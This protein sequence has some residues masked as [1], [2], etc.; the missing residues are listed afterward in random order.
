MNRIFNVIFNRITNRLEVVSELV[1][2]NKKSSSGAKNQTTLNSA[3]GKVLRF[4][5]LSLIAMLLSAPTL[6]FAAD[7]ANT[8][9]AA[10]NKPQLK[11][12]YDLNTKTLK[13]VKA[14][15]SELT[16]EDLAKLKGQ[17][18]K[19]DSD[20][21]TINFGNPETGRP[22]SLIYDNAIEIING[23]STSGSTATGTTTTTSGSPTAVS[24]ASANNM[25]NSLGSIDRTIP[26]A[27]DSSKTVQA[28]GTTPASNPTQNQGT[29]NIAYDTQY[30]TIQIL[31][32]DGQ[33]NKPDMAPDTTAG[34]SYNDLAAIL[35]NPK[36]GDDPAT[37][38]TVN[39]RLAKNSIFIGANSGVAKV[40]PKSI[41]PMDMK[42]YSVPIIKS[43]GYFMKSMKKYEAYQEGTA[44][45]YGL[46]IRDNLAIG[47]NAR[48]AEDWI[49][50]DKE[51]YLLDAF[52]ERPKNYADAFFYSS[53]SGSRY[54]NTVIGFSAVSYATR[55]T[56]LGSQSIV[57]GEGSVAI[58]DRAVAVGDR[59]ISLGS[60]S[61]SNGGVRNYALGNDDVIIGSASMGFGNTS[62]SIGRR[63]VVGHPDSDKISKDGNILSVTQ[64]HNN[65]GKGTQ[66]SVAVGVENV[67]QGKNAYTVGSSNYARGNNTA[68]MGYGV[69]ITDDR[70]IGIGTG[71]AAGST[72][73]IGDY[74]KL[75]K[76]I[77]T[78]Q[79][80]SY[81]GV[82]GE[83]YYRKFV[84]GWGAA[85]DP[86]AFLVKGTAAVGLGSYTQVN[87]NSAVALATGE[88]PAFTPATEAEKTAWGKLFAGYKENNVS[89][90]SLF[91]IYT[92]AQTKYLNAVATK[93][94]EANTLADLKAAAD[95]AKADLT[96][97][98]EEYKKNYKNSENTYWLEAMDIREARVALQE[99][100]D[101][102]T[103][104]KNDA[105]IKTKQA[106]LDKL[107]AAFRSKW[108]ASTYSFVEG[109]SAVGI[110]K[111]INVSGT[112]ALGVGRKVQVT[113]DR[114]LAVGDQAMALSDDAISFGGQAIA[115]GA[116]SMALGGK[117]YA[118]GE[119]ALAIGA[120]TKAD[121]TPES[122]VNGA[123]VPLATAASGSTAEKPNAL[124]MGAYTSV[125]G[126]NSLAIGFGKLNAQGLAKSA[127]DE[128]LGSSDIDYNS[129]TGENSIL[130]GSYSLLGADNS[131]VLGN[132][133]KIVS[134]DL[135]DRAP[136]PVNSAILGTGSIVTGSNSILIGN[137]GNIENDRIMAFGNYIHIPATDP[138]DMENDTSGSVFLGDHAGYVK[139]SKLT[140][141]LGEIEVRGQNKSLNLSEWLSS[142]KGA[143]KNYTD[144][145]T[146]V[147]LYEN[148]TTNTGGSATNS[149]NALNLAAAAAENPKEMKVIAVKSY[150]A[151]G[152]STVGVVSVGS[153]YEQTFSGDTSEDRKNAIA[154]YSAKNG[155]NIT[156]PVVLTRPITK[157]GVNI[158]Q[159]KDE[160][161]YFSV[162][163]ED[164]AK[165][166]AY[167]NLSPEE[168][169]SIKE[170]IASALNDKSTKYDIFE[171][172]RIQNVAPGLIGMNSTD[173]INGSQLYATNQMLGNLVGSMVTL[174]GDAVDVNDEGEITVNGKHKTLGWV[175]KAD[176]N[177]NSV[178]NDITYIDNKNEENENTTNLK[179][180]GDTISPSNEYTF[181]AGDNIELTQKVKSLTIA[182]AK[183]LMDIG[184]ITT[185]ETADGKHSVFNPNGFATIK[186]LQDN[187][188]NPTGA[189]QTTTVT[190][191]G[192]TVTT[193][194]PTKENPN[195]VI[196]ETSLT[197]DGLSTDGTVKVMTGLDGKD[198][199]GNP[200]ENKAVVELGKEL[201]DPND[202]TKSDNYYGTIDLVGK[203]NS[204]GT[205]F[206][207]HGDTT[208]DPSKNVPR[209]K[210][211][212]V[213]PNTNPDGAERLTYTTL[214][215]NDKDGKPTTIT[216]AI[217]TMDDGIRL[218]TSG[219]TGGTS[220]VSVLMN[221]TIR[222]ID[223]A[224]TVVSSITSSDGVHAFHID[225]NGL[226]TS[227]VD[228][229]GKALTKLGDKYY[230][231]EIVNA[232]VTKVGDNYYKNSDLDEKT[233]QPKDGVKPIDP[234]TPTS[235]ALVK[236]GDDNKE[237]SVT[238][239]TAL[240][241]VASS[242]EGEVG[243]GLNPNDSLVNGSTPETGT[244]QFIDNLLKLDPNKDADKKI[245]NSAATVTDLQKLA[246]SPL[247]FEG[248]VAE[249]AGGK[250]TFDRKLG[251]K[252]KILGGA[253]GEL[254]DKN[255]GVVSNGTDTLTVK[256]AKDLTELSSITTAKDKDGNTTKIT[257]N[258]M[259]VT[260]ATDDPDQ[261]N[262]TTFTRDGM[263]IKDYS[264]INSWGEPIEKTVSVGKDGIKLEKKDGSDDDDQDRV[265]ELTTDGLATDGK[266]TVNGTAKDPLVELNTKVDKEDDERQ[267]GNIMMKG[268]DGVEGNI[269]FE[270][271]D[272]ALTH[273]DKDGNVI[274]PNNPKDGDK[275]QTMDRMTYTTTVMDADGNPVQD[276][277]GANKVVTHQVATMDDGIRLDTSGQK[278][279]TSPVSVL[280]NQ[281]IR[282]IDGANTLVSS[283]TSSDGVHAFHID[284]NGL[285]STYVDENNNP[286][287]K[288]GDKYFTT[289]DA[290]DGITKVDDKYYKNSDL[291]KD[292]KP[293][294]NAKPIEPKEPANVALVNNDGSV[295]GKEKP[296][297]QLKN[298]ASGL[299][300]ETDITKIKGDDLNNAV[301]VGDLQKVATSPLKF[302]G[303]KSANKDG[304]NV[305]E[306]K[307][308]EQ[309]NIKG[310]ATGELSD[311]NIGVVSNDTD[312]LT[313][314]LAKELKDLTSAQF[315]GEK[316]DQTNTRPIT[317]INSDGVT[318]G[319]QDVTDPEKP[320]VTENTKLGKD[321]LSTDGNVKV[322]N[323]KNGEDLVT[324]GEGK[325]DQG[326]PD[327]AGHIVLN[328]KGGEN[329]TTP[330]ADISVVSGKP[331]LENNTVTDDNNPVNNRLDR[332]QYTDSNGKTHQVAT[333]DDGFKLDTSGQTNGSAPVSV[334]M[335]QTIRVIDGANTQVSSIASN[336]D[337]GV[338]EFHINVT[339]LPFSYTDADGQPLT[340]V[341]D[342]FYKTADLENGVPKKDAT[343]V[344]TNLIPNVVLNNPTGISKPLTLKN[345]GSGVPYQKD[346]KT[347]VPWSD[348]R[349][350]KITPEDSSLWN[351][352]V[353]LGDLKDAMDTA[354]TIANTEVT[355]SGAAIVTS[356]QAKDGHYIYNVHVDQL[357]E[358]QPVDPSQKIVR[359]GDGKYYD[360]EE[361]KG[362]TYV[363]PQ[364]GQPGKWYNSA[365]VG[366]D[367]LPKTDE[368]GHELPPL[369]GDNVPTAIAQEN[370]K[371]SV[372]NPNGNEPTVV[373][374]I[375]SAL[376][377]EVNHGSSGESV[378]VK[379][380]DGS[381]TSQKPGDNEFL[382]NL[383]ALDDKV[384]PEI[385][386][387]EAKKAAEARAAKDKAT[388]NSA[389][390][391][392]DLQKL[393]NSPLFFEGD[394]AETEGGKNTFDR[395]L[396]QKTKIL[397]GATGEL[398][399]DNIGVVSNGTDT[400][401]VKLA[402]DLTNLHS[403][404]TT[405][406][407]GKVTSMNGGG[408]V[409]TEVV[410]DST[411]TPTGE[412]KTTKV[413]PDGVSV[414]SFDPNKGEN[415]PARQTET[416]LGKD[417]LST[418][419]TVKVTNGKDGKDGKD[420]VSLNADKDGAGHIVLNGKDGENGTT[421]KAD[422]SVV[423][424]DPALR[425][426]TVTGNSPALDRIQYTD[427]QGQA[428]QVATMD[429]G[430][431][432]NTSGNDRANQNKASVLLNNTIKIVDGANTL[433]SSVVSAGGVHSFHIDVTGLPT[434]YAD[435]DNN[436][437]TKVGDQYF[438]VDDA[439]A[440]ITKVGDQYYK[441]S[442]LD[443][444]GKPVDNAKPIEPKEPASVALVNNDG[445]VSGKDTPDYQLKNIASGLGDKEL[446][447]IDKDSP[448]WNN[449]V[450][451]GDLSNFANS[452]TTK[453]FGLTGNNGTVMQ[454]LGTAITVKGGMNN[455][456]NRTD[457]N[458]YVNV[459]EVKDTNG[460]VT[461]KELIV[462]IAKNLTDL[463]SV[464]T[465]DD[466]GNRT[467]MEGTGVS[468]SD[469]D[470]NTNI[471]T[472]AGNTIADTDGNTSITT[473]AGD[474][475][476]DSKGN[477]HVSNA[478]GDTITDKDGNTN[479]STAT[480][481]TLA[482]NAG[483][484]NSSTAAGN[485]IKDANGNAT[486][487]KAGDIKTS[488]KDKDGNIATT[489][490]AG[491]NISLNKTG[492][493]GKPL[494]PKTDI[495]NNGINITPVDK[496]GNFNTS[497]QVTL[498]DKG[499]NNGGNKIINVAAGEAGTDAVNVS[500]LKESR[501]SVTTSG[502][503]E[504][505]VKENFNGS[506]EYGVHVDKLMQ[507]KAVDG[508]D[509]TRAS[510]NKYYTNAEGKT[511]AADGK[512]YNTDDIAGK[513]LKDGKWYD[514]DQFNKDGSLK[515][516]PK[517]SPVTALTGDNVPQ[518]A[519][520]K[521]SLVNVNAPDEAVK[522]DNLASSIDGKVGTELGDNT[523]I[524]NLSKVG[525]AGNPGADAAVT[526]GNLKNLADT[527]LFFTG[528]TAK[529]DKNTFGR[530]LSQE[531]KIVGGVT[532]K[533]KLSEGKNIGV[534]SNGKD[535]LTIQLAKDVK[536]LNSVETNNLTVNDGAKIGDISINGKDA[537]NQ[538]TGLSNI[539]YDPN[540]AGDYKG[541]G[542]AATEGQL[543]GAVDH[544]VA[545]GRNYAG[546]DKVEIHRA[547]GELI[548]IKGGADIN[549][550]SDNNIGVTAATDSN[551]Y[552]YLNVRLSKD[553]KDLKSAEFTDKDKDGNS[554]TTVVAGNGIAIQ[555]GNAPAVSLTSNGLDNGG[556]RITNVAP[557][558]NPT[559]AV[560]V[561]QLQNAAAGLGKRIDD[562]RKGSNAVGASAAAMAS[563]PQ[564]YIP[565]KSMVAVGTGHYR[566]ESAIAIGVS[567][568][569]DN[570]K[571][572]LKLNAGHNTD[573]HTM[574]GAGVGYQF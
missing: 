267:Y 467:K 117:A 246:N 126:K 407:N 482:D 569:S 46:R 1:S 82:D 10:N 479:S 51:G 528:D 478:A 452:L 261:P 341:G 460:K 438:T 3:T 269:T 386:D 299:G 457:K 212:A 374:N 252:T 154:A 172:R 399:D 444:D 321:G 572:I 196:R 120:F 233:G 500:Q 280:M 313:V 485:T 304:K 178:G 110:G 253:T 262:T 329:G 125:S 504:L 88:A 486:E 495:S 87:G 413:T 351:N 13:L 91:D 90:S 26:Y 194:D 384:D 372:V 517:E 63:N 298:I 287:T 55:A 570:G 69:T 555:K 283:I 481:N 400:L 361:I 475:F 513:V 378:D 446:S 242:L 11:L 286:L 368:N 175:V 122:T 244:N 30:N 518:L 62:L 289:A 370:L 301:N 553:L 419:G 364:N 54:E 141:D 284:V 191:D 165:D 44:R 435:K 167:L 94:T 83:A 312:T 529:E 293:V 521:N 387:P 173:A 42:E 181:I 306:R 143:L 66:D 541:S 160:T 315:T 128:E 2:R 394:K 260:Q 100:K 448:E 273:T 462:E 131:I 377:G 206:F 344:E 414:T 136:V 177:T 224:N 291:G 216:H 412:I 276:E 25:A 491:N 339:G 156:V 208:L 373:D 506:K 558:V 531:V 350:P 241:N 498:T 456:D 68:S 458:T 112:S 436:P 346:G 74:W 247:F 406:E 539:N 226:P 360:P 71:M 348:L 300:D 18:V 331:A 271:G 89:K 108:L 352:A 38:D 103:N 433:V 355:G 483:N 107:E 453:G 236:P 49:R 332:I 422:I 14:D 432:L 385:T 296:D 130:L 305:F 101:T 230:P 17:G 127:K 420:A 371:N 98:V 105:D 333:L 278:G 487:I 417:G 183:D 497:S 37:S 185:M 186:A 195:D 573:G 499:L 354:I 50:V 357:M 32:R 421:P 295:S 9:G 338:H 489:E 390:T 171:T 319:T 187:D 92:N 376:T 302:A 307:L 106:A 405:D 60:Y 238:D 179:T 359:G 392:R 560:N 532:D 380:P 343:P 81:T 84:R 211:K 337:S 57:G 249:T 334:L 182:V 335:N 59:S 571:I 232:G 239:P 507:P 477:T 75:A 28:V 148:S 254:S 469:K 111:Q 118:E 403:V 200:K 95:K 363:P 250:N 263:T 193:V 223:G 308:G 225:V 449:A 554:Y 113:G 480:S 408:L 356:R 70:S 562:V 516:N 99:L 282:V 76:V 222:V 476:K 551:G 353:N 402:K 133:S 240:K 61:Y 161:H 393:A 534:V 454:E 41:G 152:E 229:E 180:D 56:V 210:T 326:N 535:T 316:D 24:L 248:D 484:S 279:G 288:I 398:S 441:N 47:Q 455:T 31:N 505:S 330:K 4:F 381:V 138:K 79:G 515:E 67:V 310:G 65:D 266:V 425:N 6:V 20:G 538:I 153:V 524:D 447:A 274:D 142:T 227:Y 566:G 140:R 96:T 492:A 151:G 203:N 389:A 427:S 277:N 525:T 574:V 12:Q 45:P 294:D 199:E 35:L 281:T 303:D 72:N 365:D 565:G 116:R 382:K 546:D 5:P 220:P 391:V 115:S 451:V 493:D 327:G 471:S 490:I 496:D 564:A 366:S 510:D 309:V 508:S 523:F 557:G 184:S 548:S 146:Y 440:G 502:A 297:N 349:D 536:G 270:K 540:K 415:D 547:L 445:S 97:A 124:A 512:W 520:L 33:A 522:L 285:P 322:T 409:S 439:K 58:G 121:F 345:I 459:K 320:T 207:D 416:T 464:T 325:D 494:G 85:D 428:H 465:E 561:S 450:N 159:N 537:P 317:T 362:K 123:S 174:M 158:G 530:K 228:S 526:T 501:T 218:D 474:T 397:G 7:P 16:Q 256:L 429:D 149:P 114:A 243:N 169:K 527:P 272:T 52:G 219:Q 21:K 426:N 197:Q 461:G 73:L 162:L 404:T 559:D 257:S 430:F 188:G 217:A 245:L 258:G 251:Q 237:D 205:L 396:G 568:I 323:G 109:E 134:K 511:L 342:K 259:T 189:V 265:T 201:V 231:T 488:V 424:G 543:Q 145:Y 423:S 347:H 39:T 22:V 78:N 290:K 367:G 176:K 556:N 234:V 358:V 437:L 292:G 418:D 324:I 192:V 102:N 43:N 369:T 139:D 157:N 264:D 550:L 549:N 328:G 336:N 544:L 545:K 468:I 29:I 86:G 137:F 221:Q 470:G 135:L 166:Y 132:S 383:T 163:S 190:N 170:K 472:V 463:T 514:R 466:Q 431:F 401:T 442:D 215:L 473:A 164:I 552:Q 34:E 27:F 19:V 64:M 533:T 23:S 395:K 202:P 209:D 8:T 77:N 318:V 235:V 104:N 509:I 40:D 340:K 155:S 388:L 80:E 214:G 93:K 567:R 503:A 147:Y 563:L 129:V 311:N 213:D 314:K 150:Y 15:G 375:K 434:A 542:K 168:V 275:P 144:D 119:G 379:N 519:K 36:T 255:I 268:K 443:K 411:G 204:A 53:G 198:A 48:I 410:K